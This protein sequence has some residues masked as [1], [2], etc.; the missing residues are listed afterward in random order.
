MEY[1]INN[2]FPVKTLTQLH[3][4]QIPSVFRLKSSSEPSEGEI[5]RKSTK[6]EVNF[7]IHRLSF[8][9]QQPAFIHVYDA[10]FIHLITF[11]SIS[12][13]SKIHFTV[14]T[15]EFRIRKMMRSK[16]WSS[17]C[18]SNSEF[19]HRFSCMV[20]LA[21]HRKSIE[22]DVYIGWR[23]SFFVFSIHY[24]MPTIKSIRQK[25]ILVVY[26]RLRW[27]NREIADTKQRDKM[28]IA[29]RKSFIFPAVLSTTTNWMCVRVRVS[30][31]PQISTILRN[32]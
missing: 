14:A 29:M 24:F 11:G 6:H 26:I 22:G 28:D 9:R 18:I 16:M 23:H 3:K 1:Q 2:E 10:L 19:C 15:S 12:S 7:Y 20:S 17:E 31:C 30:V 21:S 8:Q 13:L 32:A 25:I 5:E 4:I 27:I